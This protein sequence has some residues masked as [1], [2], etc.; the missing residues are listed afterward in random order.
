MK[1]V[2]IKDGKVLYDCTGKNCT[3]PGQPHVMTLNEL[4]AAVEATQRE[5]LTCVDP[6][7]EA[8]SVVF[9]HL[10]QTLFLDGKDGSPVPDRAPW[11][12]ALHTVMKE[13]AEHYSDEDHQHEDDDA[14]K[15]SYVN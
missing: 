1:N 2:R 3:T 11:D 9:Q 10:W 7:L 8:M 13:V 6:R 5:F 12:S 14:K 4:M 15:K